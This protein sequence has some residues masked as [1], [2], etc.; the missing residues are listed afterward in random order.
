M[1]T[2]RAAFG[3][4]I[5]TATTDGSARDDVVA[6]SSDTPSPAPTR[7]RA[8]SASSPSNVIRGSKPAARHRSSVIAR[9]P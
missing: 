9:R 1:P 3:A 2:V 8:V 5:R 7:P 6:G 4:V